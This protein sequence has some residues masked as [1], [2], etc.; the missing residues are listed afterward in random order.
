MFDAPMKVLSLMRGFK[1]NWFIAGG[2]AIDLYL[3]RETRQH[4]DIEIAIFRRDQIALQN[5]LGDWVLTKA[6]NGT[7]SE[8]NR[9]ERL[10]PPVHEIHCF[11]ES[12][13]LSSLE[14][15]LNETDESNW[16]YRRNAKVAK[17]LSKLYLTSHLGINFLRPEVILLYKSKHPRLKDEQDFE[18]VAPSL[19]L[20]NKEWLKN[21][22]AVCYGEH[23][24]I[25]RL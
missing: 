13:K 17:P 2:W 25:Q 16:L 6:V 8:W 9:N 10:I 1:S 15:L 23:S 5:Y 3:E 7:L 20:E 12:A 11:N 22:L 18:S 14:V 21:A 24:W 4:E 19:D